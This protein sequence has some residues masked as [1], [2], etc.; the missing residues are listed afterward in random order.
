M[1][2]MKAKLLATVMVG[3]MTVGACEDRPGLPPAPTPP[4]APV[5]SLPALP[6][7]PTTQALLEGPRTTLSLDMLPLTVR[8]PQ[9][10]VVKALGG[11]MVLIGAAPS[12]E[13]TIQ[14]N[15]RSVKKEDVAYIEAGAK[16]EQKQQ[17]DSILVAADR[18]I[19]GM[20]VFERQTVGRSRGADGARTYR[21]TITT[22]VPRDDTYMAAYELDFVGLTDLQFNSDKTF[23]YSIVDSLRFDAVKK[24][25][26]VG[27]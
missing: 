11:T 15:V 18:E 1:M 7:R 13:I 3:T 16:D 10:W 6:E 2:C 8:V 27:Q 4:P 21:W 26:T 20:K 5:T 14:L 12:G 22:Y 24:H 17:P 23:L 25:S 19:N 9:G